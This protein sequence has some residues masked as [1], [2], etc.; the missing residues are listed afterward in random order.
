[1]PHT[2]TLKA[3]LNAAAGEDVE[4]GAAA[5]ARLKFMKRFGGRDAH[6][7][8]SYHR[9][10]A[11]A[12]A[13]DARAVAEECAALMPRRLLQRRLSAMAPAPEGY[14]LLRRV[15][16][17]SFAAF[18][19]ACYVLGIGDRHQENYLVDESSGQVVG[20]DFGHSFGNGPAKLPVPELIPFRFT[21]QLQQL[22]SPSDT[23]ALLRLQL[24]RCL[25]AYRAEAAGLGDMLEL[26]VREPIVD[27]CGGMSE[28][29]AR[30]EVDRRIRQARS[31]LAGRHPVHILVDDLRA[32]AFVRHH[33][34]GA[35]LEAIARGDGSSSLRAAPHLRDKEMLTVQEQVDTLVD[36][37]TDPNVLMRQWTGLAT[38][39]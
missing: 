11:K 9:M 17:E 5:M 20:I 39:V 12:S 19:A 13:E 31:K 1:M 35:A 2:R 33:K 15:F 27:W 28:G 26:F 21:P 30:A 25:Q 16:L 6:D 7:V 36:L 3:A 14:F 32:N 22:L 18:S 34:T 24:G 8:R 23:S 37:A 29:D 10:F 38:W 4:A